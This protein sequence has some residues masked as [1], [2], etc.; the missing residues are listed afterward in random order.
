MNIST[1]KP[2]YWAALLLCRGPM[3]D[4]RA[5]LGL[6]SVKT[7]DCLCNTTDHPLFLQALTMHPSG[8]LR[9]FW[10]E[11]Q[12]LILLQSLILLPTLILAVQSEE[13][14]TSHGLPLTLEKTGDRARDFR[15][16]LTSS[17]ADA[18]SLM[19]LFNVT[20]SSP[21]ASNLSTWS[22]STA[23]CTTDTTI[24]SCSVCGAGDVCGQLQASNMYSCNWRYIGCNGSRVNQLDL[25]NSVSLTQ[26]LY[27]PSI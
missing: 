19:G 11:L 27:D 12:L 24:T 3:M 9:S 2:G 23:P 26:F 1:V 14:H 4:A 6:L 18:N 7:N 20:V 8:R 22:L 17:N 5:V 15:S 25:T 10:V 16:L 21:S 13:A